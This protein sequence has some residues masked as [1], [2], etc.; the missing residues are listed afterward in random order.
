VPDPLTIQTFDTV[1]CPNNTIDLYAST[2]GGLG[3]AYYNYQ[4]HNSQTDSLIVV[5]PRPGNSYGVT[6]SDGCVFPVSTTPVI[7]IH[8]VPTDGLSVTEAICLGDSVIIEAPYNMASY[9]IVAEGVDVMDEPYSVVYPTQPGE[10]PVLMQIF[11]NQGC[12]KLDTTSFT[13][14][15][16]PVAE[17]T[18]DETVE[19]QVRKNGV[20]DFENNSTNNAK[21]AWFYRNDLVSNEIDLSYDFLE[22]GRHFIELVVRNPIGCAD[23]ATQMVIVTP[24]Q[25]LFIPNSFTPNNDNLNDTWELI[26][27][28]HIDE[29]DLWVLDRWGSVVWESH[30]RNN[31]VWDGTDMRNGTRVPSGTYVYRLYVASPENELDYQEELNGTIQI[32]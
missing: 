23:S 25:G 4:W 10:Y 29:F 14:Y 16:Y 24:D 2:T 15:E 3:P 9:R 31:N 21:N 19:Y 13:V 17:F 27:P 8:P 22:P 20:V 28:D 32:F 1:L 26:V 11:T 18:Y 30:D 6:V 7:T 5:S 12:E